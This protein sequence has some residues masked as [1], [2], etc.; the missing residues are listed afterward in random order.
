M[1]SL[2]LK[3]PVVITE[4]CEKILNFPKCAMLI[5]KRWGRREEKWLGGI[6]DETWRQSESQFL[7]PKRYCTCDCG[8]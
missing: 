3:G 8:G 6:F 7:F 5:E 4:E 2:G 1:D